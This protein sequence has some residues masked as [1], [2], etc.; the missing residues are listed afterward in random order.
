VACSVGGIS[1]T[2]RTECSAPLATASRES[3]LLTTCW[4]KSTSSSRRFSGPASRHGNLNSLF[5]I[6]LHLP[7]LYF[8]SNY[9]QQPLSVAPCPHSRRHAPV[10]A[11][12]SPSVPSPPS[13]PPNRRRVPVTPTSPSSQP[14]LLSC[15]P[16]RNRPSRRPLQPVAPSTLAQS[17]VPT[18][19][20]QHF[21]SKC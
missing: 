19:K 13:I 16:F 21:H 5:Q 9:Y 14:R 10:D 7:S 20:E 6:A 4:S 18:R 1:P 2:L 12:R 11:P 15:T 3:S 17:S 8:S